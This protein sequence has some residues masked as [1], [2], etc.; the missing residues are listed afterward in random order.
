[1]AWT[2]NGRWWAGPAGSLVSNVIVQYVAYKA[3]TPHKSATVTTADTVGTGPAAV[4]AGR[5]GASVVWT[6][7]FPGVVTVYT[8]GPQP[9]GL[10]PGRT[11]VLLVPKGTRVSAS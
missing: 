1:M 6:R 5:H 2:W 7:R 3:L 4:Y 8:M 11:W 9:V 10:V